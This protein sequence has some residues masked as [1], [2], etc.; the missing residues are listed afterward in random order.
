MD[1]LNFFSV[2]KHEEDSTFIEEEEQE[3]KDTRQY[4]LVS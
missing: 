1:F 3:H 4:L 2:Y